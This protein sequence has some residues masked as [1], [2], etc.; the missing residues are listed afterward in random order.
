MVR[1]DY[2]IISGNPWI[3]DITELWTSFR[4][5]VI[6]LDASNKEWLC[7]KWSEEMDSLKIPY[8]NVPSTGALVVDL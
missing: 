7:R 8:H 6:I 5:P 1:L 4:K 3:E 2:L